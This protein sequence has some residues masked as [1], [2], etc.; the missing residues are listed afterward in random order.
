MNRLEAIVEKSAET[1][2]EISL[3]TGEQV[4]GVESILKSLER[5]QEGI[6]RLAGVLKD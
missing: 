2:T 6:E 3:S 4:S 1:T 5:V